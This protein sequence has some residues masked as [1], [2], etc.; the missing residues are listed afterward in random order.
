MGV[1][2]AEQRRLFD[3]FYRA[4]LAQERAIEG[5][6]LGLTIARAIVDAH[7]GSITFTSV[8]GEGTTFRVRLPLAGPHVYE[9][10]SRAARTESLV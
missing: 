5:T 3:R 6:G 8:E 10:A 4:S 7:G 1:P 9:A 2:A